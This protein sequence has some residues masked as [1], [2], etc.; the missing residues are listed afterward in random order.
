MT[1]IKKMHEYSILTYSLIVSKLVNN[2]ILIPNLHPDHNFNLFIL[3][4]LNWTLTLS[5]VTLTLILTVIFN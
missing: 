3:L 4:T 1:S 5:Y 2:L